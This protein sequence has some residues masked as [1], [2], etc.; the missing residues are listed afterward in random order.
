[1]LIM[2]GNAEEVERENSWW[3]DLPRKI[4]RIAEGESSSCKGMH[5]VSSRETKRMRCRALCIQQ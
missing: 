1:M 3:A 4:K 2:D 5:Q